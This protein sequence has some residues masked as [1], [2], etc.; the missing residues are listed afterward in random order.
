MSLEAS[1]TI[2]PSLSAF[3]SAPRPRETEADG[4]AEPNEKSSSLLVQCMKYPRSEERE[5]CVIPGSLLQDWK[6]PSREP[7]PAPRAIRASPFEPLVHKRNLP[8]DGTISPLKMDE[9]YAS[10]AQPGPT[11]QEP[12]KFLPPI[13]EIRIPTP[14]EQAETRAEQPPQIDEDWKTLYFC[15][16]RDLHRAQMENYR[17]AEENRLLKRQLIEMQRNLFEYRRNPPAFPAENVVWSIPQSRK[18][19]QRERKDSPAAEN[20]QDMSLDIDENEAARVLP[21]LSS[22]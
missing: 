18:K 4:R 15:S 21:A 10:K 17:M 3:S 14:S 9:Y 11:K 13:A 16:Q 20:A 7:C 6:M 22:S 2:C 8:K 5:Q 19:V 1:F 12:T